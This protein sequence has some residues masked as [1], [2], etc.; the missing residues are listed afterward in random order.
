MDFGAMNP[1]RPEQNDTP[2]SRGAAE[3]HGRLEGLAPQGFQAPPAWTA[4][5][6]LPLPA[7]IMRA[8]GGAEYFNVA[9]R[10]RVDARPASGRERDWLQRVHPDDQFEVRRRWGNAAQSG[11]PFEVEC[12]VCHVSG[13]YRWCALSA[14]AQPFGGGARW[15]V[16]CTD[17][18]PHRLREAA[19]ADEARARNDM[20]DVS[21]D[22]IK[23]ISPAGRLS[24][25]NR[26]GCLA[27]GV[28]EASGFGM[29][30]LDLLPKAVR[31]RGQRALAAA[32]AGKNARFAGMSQM[33]G[34]KPQYWDNILT[35]LKNEHGE[36]TR[37]L[38]VSREVTAQREAQHR[39]RAA[40]DEDGL[41]GLLNRRAFNARL[42]RLMAKARKA[43]KRVGL[44]LI[45]LDY[46]KQ[47]NDSLGH[48][49][50]DHLLRVLAGRLKSCFQHN[51]FVA[52][53]GGDEFV[54]VLTDMADMADA[55][56]EA[57]LMQAA[58]VALA[59]A[60]TPVMY[61]GRQINGG[62]SI[63]T[64]MFP[65]DAE[66]I[67]GLMKCADTALNDL[68]ANGRGGARHYN[69]PMRQAALAVVAQLGRA[70]QIV[71]DDAVAPLY[72]PSVCL[73]DGHVVGYEALLSWYGGGS[74]HDGGCDRVQDWQPAASIGE[75]FNDYQLA[76][77][78]SGR[79][80]ERVFADMAAWQRQGLAP[81][82]VAINVASVE[83]LR[84][85]F[86]DRLIQ[87]LARFGIAPSL[88]ALQITEHSF[89]ERGA[90][91]VM[92]ALRRLKPLGVRVFIDNFGMGHLALT[93]LASYPVDGLRIGGAFVD[94]MTT[95]AP[96][97]AI[98]RAIG[99]LGASLSL[100]VVATGVETAQ[101]H[102]LLAAAG[103]SIGQGALFS[104]VMTGR[105]VAASLE[106]V[107]PEAP[108]QTQP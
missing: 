28:S 34:Q 64:A 67:P 25:L 11:A 102:V 74:A 22:C 96:M 80:Q 104:G 60:G 100:R 89:F 32:C 88:V 3:A 87:R 5:D 49:A 29:R 97:L 91:F 90:E 79:L 21:V 71:R 47:T 108:R 45:D 99:M 36:T 37:I 1:A 65:G 95:E 58:E 85:D 13:A 20:L 86:A 33:P 92:R 82:P 44:M 62:M 59:Q 93:H 26:S 18:H 43:G 30:W 78:L 66:D 101:Q 7:W 70:R 8:D 19:L 41:T 46:F 57:A 103:C 61:A 39:L 52:R 94:R 51:G 76:T 105:Q 98:V 15:T 69:E 16:T 35:P 63:G 27:L 53:L 56:D 55:A 9:W 17:M 48:A 106:R 42:K 2:P 73:C 75:A 54:V 38:C 68:K 83:F 84:D 12:R 14:S 4:L 77:Q 31:R 6:S 10:A 107:A 81:L 72:Q 24:H 40:S 50:G 23:V